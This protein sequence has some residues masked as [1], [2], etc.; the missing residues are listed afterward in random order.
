M[1]RHRDRCETT[2]FVRRA[3][4]PADGPRAALHGEQIEIAV[5]VVVEQRA[6]GSDDLGQQQL[7]GRA[8]H[9]I[10][11]QAGLCRNISKWT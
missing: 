3:R 7:T 5:V 4:S 9:M 11:G 2:G 1:P 10:E 6:A 8:V